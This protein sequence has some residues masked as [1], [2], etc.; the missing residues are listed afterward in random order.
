MSFRRHDVTKNNSFVPKEK[1]TRCYK[2]TKKQKFMPDKMKPS[3][4]ALFSP[5][6]I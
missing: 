3:L 5:I 1:P 2:P 4:Y 6:P